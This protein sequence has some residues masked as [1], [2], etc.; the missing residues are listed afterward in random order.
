MVLTTKCPNFGTCNKGGV[1]LTC[2]GM[3]WLGVCHDEV[4]LGA[5]DPPENPFPM[6]YSATLSIIFQTLLVSSLGWLLSVL[7]DEGDSDRH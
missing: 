2:K 7:E 4:I 5:S 3:R 1:R 6:N